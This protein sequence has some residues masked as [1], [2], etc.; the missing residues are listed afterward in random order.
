MENLKS[1]ST[2]AYGAADPQK[3][4]ICAYCAAEAVL[5]A[6]HTMVG[7]LSTTCGIGEAKAID[8]RIFRVA[9]IMHTVSMIQEPPTPL[10]ITLT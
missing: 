4:T 7:C 9:C 10:H 1:V 3:R 8:I 6:A 5:D 2:D